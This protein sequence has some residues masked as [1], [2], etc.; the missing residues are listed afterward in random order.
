MTT[1]KDYALHY[2]DHGLIPIP[3]CWVRDGRCA[4]FHHHTD[5]KQIGKAPLVS[6]IKQEIKRETIE[7]WFRS[8][9]LSNIGI[10]IKAFFENPMRHVVSFTRD[11]FAFAA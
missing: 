11:P 6:Y 8:F 10:L 5:A 2:F 3:L 1:K 7:K 9:P 4:C